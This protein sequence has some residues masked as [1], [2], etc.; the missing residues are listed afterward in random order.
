M[1]IFAFTGSL[2][3]PMPQYGAANGRGL[4]Q[5]GFDDE[6]GRLTVIGEIGGIDDTGWL[7][8][9]PARHTLY[10][11]CEITGADRSSVA[12]FAVNDG[13]L[14]AR[15]V[16]PTGGN[17]ACHASL[18][19][20]G[21]FLLVAT[22]NG[23]N[24]PGAPDAAVTVYPL[25]AGMPGLAITSVRHQGSGPNRERQTAAH[26]H[27]VIPS[28]DG[29][30]IY[31]ADLGMDR[32]VVYALGADGSLTPKPGNDYALPPGLGPRHLVFHP[33]GRLLFL[34]SELIPTVM[35][36][37]VDPTTG[38]LS[39]RSAVPI[40]P[41][42][43]GP[44]D[45]IVQPAGIVLTPDGRFLFA[46][47]RVSNDILGLA[48]DPATGALTQTGRW[49]SGGATPRDLALSPSGRHLLV[50][51]QDSDAISVFRVDRRHGTLSGPIHNQPVGTPMTVKLAAF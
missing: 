21:R 2:T 16:Q 46:S 10:T 3:R 27:C 19:P 23:A 44:G 22:Y 8:L 48:V 14:A 49:P 28:P 37:A 31:V 45:G 6:A 4:T 33:N 43:D 15:G 34:V 36:L 50:A 12:A 40:A 51:N 41:P 29:R 39:P 47:L 25:V 35:S 38:V 42:G 32:L 18:S 7:V 11:T 24:P 26:A 5:F 9:D 30:F 17:E 1:P 13:G 20:D